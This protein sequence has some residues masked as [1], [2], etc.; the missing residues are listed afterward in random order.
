MAI[1]SARSELGIAACSIL[2]RFF[3]PA[4]GFLSTLVPNTRNLSKSRR[5]PASAKA[6]GRV[7]GA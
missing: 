7:S 4:R 6:R 5:D 1:T 2:A 3:R